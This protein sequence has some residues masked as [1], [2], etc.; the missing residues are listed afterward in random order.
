MTDTLPPFTLPF[1]ERWN[2]DV[3]RSMDFGGRDTPILHTPPPPPLPYFEI[4]GKGE[5]P[6]NL[7]EERRERERW[8]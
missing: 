3:S 8:K 6:E 5:I 1:P 2:R 4:S 7:D